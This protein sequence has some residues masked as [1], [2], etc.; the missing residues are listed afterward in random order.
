MQEVLSRYSLME[1]SDREYTLTTL[2]SPPEARYM[3]E[4]E[5]ETVLILPVLPRYRL[6]SLPSRVTILRIWSPPP[7]AIYLPSGEN[8]IQ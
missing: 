6:V 7:T 5:K 4:G 1:E 8:A 2:S 3:P